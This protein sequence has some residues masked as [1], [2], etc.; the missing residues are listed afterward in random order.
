M[1]EILYTIPVIVAVAVFLI[2]DTTV[3]GSSK[4]DGRFDFSSR[5]KKL[6]KQKQQEMKHYVEQ[7]Q[8]MHAAELK[9]SSNMRNAAKH[10]QSVI[11]DYKSQAKIKA[12]L[13]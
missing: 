1:E 9:A 8:K 10:M 4:K 3:V 5:F 2:A 13:E 12:D 6:P 11:E 7:L